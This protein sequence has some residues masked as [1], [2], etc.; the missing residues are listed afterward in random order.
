MFLQN[1]QTKMNCKPKRHILGWQVMPKNL[2]KYKNFHLNIKLYLYKNKAKQ[3]ISLHVKLYNLKNSLKEYT[4]ME[5]YT[6]YELEYSV[7]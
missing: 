7:M 5:A 3:N 1:K 2:K 6:V 4:E